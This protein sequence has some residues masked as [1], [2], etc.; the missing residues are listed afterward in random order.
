MTAPATIAN[1]LTID[2]EDYFQVQAYAGAI[3]RADWDKIPRRVEANTDLILTALAR[4]GTRATFFTLG[5]VA[6]RH[7]ALI[8][9]ITAAGHE[10]ASHGYGHQLVTDLTPQQFRDDLTRAKAILEDIGGVAVAGYRAPTFSIGPRNPWAWDVLAETGHTYSSSV[11]PVRHDLYGAPSAPRGPY[12]PAAC[13]L[14]EIPMTTVQLLGRNL[15]CAGGGYFRLLPYAAYRFGVRHL[16]RREGR[17]AIFYSHPWE[18]DPAQPSVPAAKWSSR[19]RHRVNLARMPAR[20]DDLLADFTWDR[21]DR[22]F[23]DVIARAAA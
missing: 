16:H 15:P 14:V 13:N 17:P 11:F 1:A 3:D 6:E 12:Q 21:M 18:F 2:V 4:H 10:L 5:W 8:R 19:F 20:L 23:A 9:R 22:V 7:P